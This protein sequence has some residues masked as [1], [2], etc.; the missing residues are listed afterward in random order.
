[1]SIPRI[2]AYDV[3]N[4]AVS[5]IRSASRTTS[6]VGARVSAIVLPARGW[7]D[8][9]L[10]GQP[11]ELMAAALPRMV[12]PDGRQWSP[13]EM[14]LEFEN[15]GISRLQR[16]SL[17]YQALLDNRISVRWKRRLRRI[18]SGEF[19]APTVYQLIALLF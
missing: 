13:S 9:G 6:A 18:K 17:L 16:H 8:T 12:Y 5:R 3:A 11:R 1:M 2:Q 19:V 15:C 14:I 4:L 10:W 7:V